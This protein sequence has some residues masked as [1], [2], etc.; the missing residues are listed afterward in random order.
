MKGRKGI[1]EEGREGE[2]EEAVIRGKMN[3]RQ[4]KRN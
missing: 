1:R 4:G 3:S 2:N